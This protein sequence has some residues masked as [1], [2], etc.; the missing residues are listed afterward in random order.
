MVK[1]NIADIIFLFTVLHDF[2][3]PKEVLKNCRTM[4]K[5]TGRLFN[6]DWQAKA[7]TFGPPLEKRFSLA[8]CHDLINQS[9]FKIVKSS[10][11]NQDYYLVEA[12]K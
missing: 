2:T 3:D 10:N 6:L 7:T 1:E 12:K 9:K 8:K 4:L 5:P 11:F